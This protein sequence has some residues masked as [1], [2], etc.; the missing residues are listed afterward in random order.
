MVRT[1]QQRATLKRQRLGHGII[2]MTAV[3]K[4]DLALRAAGRHAFLSSMQ[5]QMERLARET[6]EVAVNIVERLH[7]PLRDTERARKSLRHLKRSLF[8]LDEICSHSDSWGFRSV[9]KACQGVI[10]SMGSLEEEAAYDV[11]V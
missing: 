11:D 10:E 4:L 7:G 3:R 1:R 9:C 2:F 5:Q 6:G 8:R